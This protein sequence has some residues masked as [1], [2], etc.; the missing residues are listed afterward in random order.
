[1][2]HAKLC[3]NTSHQAF[4]SIREH[5]GWPVTLR[6]MCRRAAVCHAWPR[7]SVPTIQWSPSTQARTPT[8]PTAL[9][10]RVLQAAEVSMQSMPLSSAVSKG[11]REV[12]H[13][14]HRSG[15]AFGS[16]GHSHVV[17]VTVLTAVT[18]GVFFAAASALVR[19]WRLKAAR[20]HFS[21]CA[22]VDA[23]G[24]PLKGGQRF[25]GG[26][27]GK[28]CPISDP[29]APYSPFPT[30][31]SLPPSRPPSLPIGALRC[32][33]AALPRHSRTTLCCSIACARL[34]DD[35]SSR[36]PQPSDV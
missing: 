29:L 30:P 18:C 9:A 15:M 21:W 32:C 25:N 23:H 10:E 36:P 31:P 13:A 19:R 26:G 24:K 20:L 27:S 4:I 3:C 22:Q 8:H 7:H 17:R 34:S 11:S 2:L 14:S 6:R 12:S 16:T 5:C 35:H 28:A 1:L 33:L